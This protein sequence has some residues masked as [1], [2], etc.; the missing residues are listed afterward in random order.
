M[1]MNKVTN[2]PFAKFLASAISNALSGLVD[3]VP[4]DY[5]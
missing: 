4:D 2:L 3:G 1:A 5:D